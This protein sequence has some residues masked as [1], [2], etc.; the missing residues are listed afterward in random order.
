MP[1]TFLVASW[2]VSI[3]CPRNY[4]P[5]P[6]VIG[7]RLLKKKVRSKRDGIGLSFRLV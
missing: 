1:G 6:T 3:P 2:S 5:K 7:R 4:M